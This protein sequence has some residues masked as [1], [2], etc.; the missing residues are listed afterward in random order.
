MARDLPSVG[1]P[2]GGLVYRV[3]RGEDAFAPPPWEYVFKD[4][5]F[6]NRYDD[7]RADRNVPEEERFR[8]TFVLST[9]PRGEPERTG[10]R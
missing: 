4:G 1:P 2:D 3:G 6:N 10:K 8:V 5:T 7:P 9:V